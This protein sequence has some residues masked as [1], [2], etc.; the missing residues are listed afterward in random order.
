MF[1]AWTLRSTE[2]AARET[3]LRERVRAL[4]DADRS[5]YWHRLTPQLKD[6]DTYAVLDWILLAGLHHLY[7]GHWL[8]GSVNLAA[9]LGG[10]ALLRVR[11]EIGCGLIALVLV[12]ELPALFR[13]QIIVADHNLRLGEAIVAELGGQRSPPG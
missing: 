1:E 10:I 9:M 3:A 7:L 11:P 2:V 5:R 4:G 6:P 12:A 13:S 8:A